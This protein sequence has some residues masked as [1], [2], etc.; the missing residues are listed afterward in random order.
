MYAS[1]SSSGIYRTALPITHSTVGITEELFGEKISVYPNPTA[2]KIVVT[3]DLQGTC[4][5]N[6]YDEKGAMIFSSQ[7]SAEKAEID[8]SVFPSGIYLLEINNGTTSA[9]KKIIR[10]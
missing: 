4:L 9:F 6:L 7:L 1:P 8:L 5:Y 2:D 10:K 3:S